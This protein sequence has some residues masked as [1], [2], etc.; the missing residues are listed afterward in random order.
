[1]PTSVEAMSA[2]PGLG[3][4]RRERYGQELLA[5]LDRFRPTA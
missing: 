2:V 3:D 4:W 5:V 1:M